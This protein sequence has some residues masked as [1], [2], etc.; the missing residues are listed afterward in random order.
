M[1]ATLYPLS[2]PRAASTS[3]E[4]LEGFIFRLEN[5]NEICQYSKSREFLEIV[6]M[7][8]DHKENFTLEFV[9]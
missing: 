5:S 1:K 4:K 8:Y 7:H 3:H 2:N 9:L 6:C